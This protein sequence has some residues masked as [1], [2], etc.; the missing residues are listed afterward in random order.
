MVFDTDIRSCN[1]ADARTLSFGTICSSL[2]SRLSRD[3]AVFGSFASSINAAPCSRKAALSGSSSSS[4]GA[5]SPVEESIGLLL[6]VSQNSSGAG[7][8]GGVDGDAV[9]PKI[10]ARLA[11]LSS[12][13]MARRPRTVQARRRAKLRGRRSLPPSRSARLRRVAAEWQSPSLFEAVGSCMAP[14]R[15]PQQ[16]AKQESLDDQEADLRATRHYLLA[17]YVLVSR[18]RDIFCRERASLARRGLVTVPDPAQICRS[19]PF[20]DAWSAPQLLG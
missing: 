1:V 8:G 5:A 4:T 20:L 15:W 18:N 19:R 13:F 9:A 6:S 3:G 12:S 10:C 14:R 16:P 11:R 17:S 7:A 2:Y